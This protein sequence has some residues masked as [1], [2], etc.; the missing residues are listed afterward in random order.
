MNPQVLTLFGEELAPEQINAVGK[1][2]AKPK[3]QNTDKAPKA[4]TIIKAKK[5]KA[6]T[7]PKKK[8][9][10][11]PSSSILVG[12]SPEKQYYSIG[13]VA[14]LFQV[15]TSHIRFWTNEFGLKVRTTRK[16][17]RLYTPD[18][19]LE[20]KK[21]H[22]LVKERGFTLAGAKAKLKEKKKGVAEEADLRQGLLK[23]R[24]QLVSMR[25]QLGK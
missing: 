9:V 4:E 16:G 18:Q 22:H 3:K 19:I 25:N 20:L 24:N 7:G 17:D 10:L 15:N 2:R 21:I 14:A 1:S 13:E 12:W 8:K 6:A 5:L 11:E 23:L